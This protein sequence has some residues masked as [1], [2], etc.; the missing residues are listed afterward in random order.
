M[1]LLDTHVWVCWAASAPKLSKKAEKVI[2]EAKIIYVSVISCWEIAMLVSKGRLI[3]DR[4]V[5]VWLNLALKLPRLRLTPLDS[6]D[7]STEQ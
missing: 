2:N 6:E 7:S 3:F 5:E 1:I 4:D